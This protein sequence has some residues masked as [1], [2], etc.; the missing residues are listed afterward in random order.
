MKTLS[1]FKSEQNVSTIDLIQGTGRA[2]ATVRDQKLYVASKTDL[3]KPLY[4]STLRRANADVV[5]DE[6]TVLD[7]TNS[8]IDPKSH[9][10]VNSN[11]KTVGSI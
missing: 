11:V 6:N 10:L 7:D 2:F 9:W 8:T 4:V 1:Q 3:S 5:V